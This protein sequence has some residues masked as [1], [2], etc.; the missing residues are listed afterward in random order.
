[1]RV[2]DISTESVEGAIDE[3]HV[4]PEHIGRELRVA[5][6][7]QGEGGPNWR[8][9]RSYWRSRGR[10]FAARGRSAWAKAENVSA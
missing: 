10:R 2:D 9:L 5:D 7:L 1:M 4:M 8:R 6:R 3:G